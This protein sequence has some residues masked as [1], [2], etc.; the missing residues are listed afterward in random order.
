MPLCVGMSASY[1]SGAVLGGDDGEPLGGSGL[2]DD[3]DIVTTA[4]HRNASAEARF[5]HAQEMPCLVSPGKRPTAYTRSLVQ[6]ASRNVNDGPIPGDLPQ[7]RNY[8]P[9]IGS[10]RESRVRPQASKAQVS[11]HGVRPVLCSVL[12]IRFGESDRYP[13]RRACHRAGTHSMV[14]VAH[15]SHARS[16]E[17]G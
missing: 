2:D 11:V 5:R 1:Q 10:R 3:G 12:A 17:G 7:H 4:P 16:E 6:G 14:P 8:M 9:W 13:R 15:K